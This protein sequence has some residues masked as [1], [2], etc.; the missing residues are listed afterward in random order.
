MYSF[1]LH[2]EHILCNRELFDHIKIDLQ[3]K[4]M[5]GVLS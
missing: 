1:K 4:I 5:C 2:V 3:I